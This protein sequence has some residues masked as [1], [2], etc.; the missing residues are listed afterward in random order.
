MSR[1]AAILP[2][3]SRTHLLDD[4][5]AVPLVDAP[6]V[7]TVIAWPPHTHSRPLAALVRTATRL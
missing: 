3:S 4:L 1:A 7:I 5:T 6:K 2:E